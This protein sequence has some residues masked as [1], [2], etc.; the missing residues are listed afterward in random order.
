MADILVVDDDQS[1]ATAFER[2]LDAEGHACRLASGAAEAM[3]MIEQQPP[4]VVIMDIRMPGV[5]GLQA[6]QQ[7]RSRFPGIYIVMMTAYGTSQTSI[8]AIRSGAFD[9][10]TKP[11][12]LDQLREVIGKALTAQQVVEHPAAPNGSEGTT[13]PVVSLVGDTPVMLEVYKMIGRLATNSAPAL[14]TGER[15]TGKHLVVATIHE[16]SERRERPLLTVNC[17]NVSEAEVDVALSADG[18]GTVELDDVHLLPLPLQAIVAQT[19]AAARTKGAVPR[20]TARI[21][22]TS[23]R[24]L[25]DETR[26][27]RF[28]QALY[29]ELAVVTLRLRP[30]R[31]RRD[32]IPLL[33]RQ[34]IQRFNVELNR[35]IRGVEDQVDRALEQHSWP[36]NVGELERVIKRACIVARSNVITMDD[37][38]DSLADSRFPGRPDVESTLERSVRGALHERLVQSR[39]PESSPFHDVV[40]AVESVL[41]REALVITNGNQLKA[42]EILGVNRATLRKKMPNDG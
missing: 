5:D 25:A 39:G 35:D 23:D 16:N 27:G 17:A 7:F 42:A 33:V 2:F 3:R 6:L 22:A 15:G 12:D 14:V 1:V 29:D 19:L 26:A 13:A 9:Y 32:D 10:L 8:D 28:A 40:D 36:G 4:N 31:E 41:V 30:L 20:L 38:R 37:V 11:L 34:F 21:I 24:D 18:A